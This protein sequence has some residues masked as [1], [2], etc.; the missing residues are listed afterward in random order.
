MELTKSKGKAS[1][2]RKWS[3][4]VKDS[5]ILTIEDRYVTLTPSRY[6]SVRQAEPGAMIWKRHFHNA[7]TCQGDNDTSVKR[8]PAAV[9]AG[10]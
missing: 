10:R 2:Q 5:E 7:E 4:G 1:E 9:K 8:S 3:E 6:P